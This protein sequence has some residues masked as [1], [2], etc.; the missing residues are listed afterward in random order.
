MTRKINEP[1]HGGARTGAGRKALP[2]AQKRR[3]KVMVRYT[4]D[5]LAELQRA[6]D[7]AGK[8]VAELVWERSL[9]IR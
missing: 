9:S 8:S 5:E 3:N 6:A 7:A 4:D 1:T 2:E